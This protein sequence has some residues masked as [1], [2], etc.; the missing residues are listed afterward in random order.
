M[1]LK[2]TFSVEMEDGSEYEVT[3]D[4]RDFRAWEAWKGESVIGSDA[5]LTRLAEWAYLAGRRQG[6]WNGK[7]EDWE[8]GCVGV[9]MK[10]SDAVRPTS[11]APSERDSSPSQSEQESAPRTGKSR[12]KKPS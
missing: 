3:A 10:R 1:S 7:Y 9:T 4:G 11:G 12:A 6:L 8:P 2:Q 5:S